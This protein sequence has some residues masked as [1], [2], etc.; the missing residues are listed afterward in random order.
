VANKKY[1]L[2]QELSLGSAGKKRGPAP[3]ATYQRRFAGATHL[4]EEIGEKTG[5]MRDLKA[6]FPQWHQ[7]I[8]SLAYYLVLEPD[9]PLYRL[10]RWAVTHESPC[11]RAIPSQR[12]SELLPRITEECKMDFLKRQAKRRSETEYLFYDST[13]ISSSSEQ[14]K[15]VKFGKR[16]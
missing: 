12:G 1:R 10:G 8:R 4:L 2:Q 6:S 15:Q 3:A 16:R 14:L 13:S 9:T 7:E 11:G 5:V